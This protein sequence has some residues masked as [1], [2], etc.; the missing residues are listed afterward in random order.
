MN[1]TS[2]LPSLFPEPQQSDLPRLCVGTS[3]YSFRDWVGPFYPL[4]VPARQHLEYYAAHFPCLEVN[5]THYRLPDASFLQRMCERTPASFGF[6]VKLHQS[7]THGSGLDA[8]SLQAF[9]AALQPMQ[10]CDKLQGVLAQFPFRF[11]N[12]H[13]NRNHLARLRE[14]FAQVP[15]FAEFRHASWIEDRS[16]DLLRRLGVG[17]VCV[18]EPPLD[19]LV[20]PVVRATTEV[21]YVR[22]HGRNART[23]YARS[24]EEG[25]RY[26]YLYDES[27]LQEWAQRIRRLIRET[28]RVFVLFN[29]CHAGKAPANAQAMKEILALLEE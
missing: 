19:N 12:T 21:G 11:H 1:A 25:D 14:S 6:L 3:G 8:P 2:A 29:N 15:F 16:F 28:R 4:R 23:W 9:G 22:L 7:M 10:E 20:P 24:P 27:E 26:D 18:D 13:A 17:Y 5:V